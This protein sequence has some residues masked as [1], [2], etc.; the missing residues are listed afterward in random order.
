MKN[1]N[2]RSKGQYRALALVAGNAKAKSAPAVGLQMSFFASAYREYLRKR[3][4]P[5]AITGYIRDADFQKTMAGLY[6]SKMQA[7]SYI[8]ELRNNTRGRCC[9]FCGSLNNNQIDHYLPQDYYPEFSV[10]LPNLFPIC[11]CNQSKGK[12]TVG[13]FQ[14]ERFLHPKFDRKIGERSLYVRIRC[15]YDAPTYTVRFRKPRGVRDAAAF[16]FHTR[17]LIS[18][19]AL[20]NYVKEGFERFCARPGNVIRPLK[21]VN[22]NSKEHL[23][24]MLRDEIAEVCWQHQTKNNWES[25]MLQ[26]LIERRTVKWLWKRLSAPGREAGGPLVPV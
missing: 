17:N 8:A 10:F 20:T 3:G 13:A 24:R 4:N 9:A 19:D 11:S 15:H 12:K 16:D 6:V 14:G 7:V 18:Q 22:P 2:H 21:Y 23:V 1:F 25:V 26:A 5:W